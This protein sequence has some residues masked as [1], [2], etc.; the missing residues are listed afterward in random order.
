MKDSV[1]DFF[2]SHVE[3]EISDA[4]SRMAAGTCTS[5][6]AYQAEVVRI[7]TLD[8]SLEL[9]KRAMKSAYNSNND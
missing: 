2:R 9:L 7:K 3:K 5:Y 6:E 4:K 1:V 8:E